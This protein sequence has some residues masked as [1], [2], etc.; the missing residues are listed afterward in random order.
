MV[1]DV[2]TQGREHKD[3]ER[4]AYKQLIPVRTSSVVTEYKR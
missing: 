1:A 3:N 4:N 2:L